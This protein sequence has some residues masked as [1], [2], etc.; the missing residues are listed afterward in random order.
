MRQ[1]GY[2]EGSEEP[3]LGPLLVGQVTSCSWLGQRPE[4]PCE[5]GPGLGATPVSKLFHR[6][7]VRSVYPMEML[8]KLW[9]QEGVLCGYAWL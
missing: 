2:D 5:Y 1:E 9:G 8:A 3:R 4:V 7:Q 6:Q